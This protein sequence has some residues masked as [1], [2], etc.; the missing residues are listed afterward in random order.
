MEKV[1][2]PFS[3]AKDRIAGMAGMRKEMEKELDVLY[4]SLKPYSKQVG[5]TTIENFIDSPDAISASYKPDI[6]K[7]LK[8]LYTLAM[9]A[10]SQ[11]HP[12]IMTVLTQVAPEQ[13]E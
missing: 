12:H 4:N 10:I 7:V 5:I 11:I 6:F 13:N 3:S 1:L 8:D 9:K 2:E